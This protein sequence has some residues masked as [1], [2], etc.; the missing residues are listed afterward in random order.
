VNGHR[1]FNTGARPSSARL[2]E[3]NRVGAHGG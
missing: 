2:R 3:P 1:A